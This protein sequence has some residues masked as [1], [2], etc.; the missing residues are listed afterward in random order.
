MKSNYNIEEYFVL[1]GSINILTGK[2]EEGINTA[3]VCNIVFN[4]DKGILETISDHSITFLHH[5][6][7]L[8][9]VR[10]DKVIYK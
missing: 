10:I 8:G 3:T 5:N 2:V 9:T 1:R 4:K 6:S 7:P